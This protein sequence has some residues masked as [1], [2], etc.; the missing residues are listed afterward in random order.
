ML[1]ELASKVEH[2]YCLGWALSQSK[3]FDSQETLLLIQGLGSTEATRRDAFAGLLNGR[4]AI[5]G[6]T[7]LEGLRS[8][9]T[10]KRWTLQQ[11]VDYYILLPFVQSTW[12]ALEDEEAEIQRLYWA[13]ICINGRGDL[14]PKDCEYVI[15]KLAE[16]ERLWAAVDFMALYKN[17]MGN[18]A[19][20]VAEVLDRAILDKRTKGIDWGFVAYGV[21]ELLDLLE[22]SNEIEKAQIAQFE[23]FFLPLLRNYRRPKI[24]YKALTNDPE[25][26]AE[27]LKWPYRAKGEEPSEPTEEKSIRA[28][29]GYDLLRSWTHPPGVNEDGSVDPEKLRS[30]ITRARELTHANGRADVADHHIG[31]VLAHYPK[32]IDGAWPH[33][34]LRD[35]IE[36]LGS[37]EIE[38]GIIIGI[39]NS[40]GVISRSIGEGGTQEREIAERYLDY[41]RKLSDNWPRTARLVKK[42]ADGYELDARRE[43]KRAEL[44]E[45]LM[46]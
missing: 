15:L 28:R 9:E 32:G 33:E 4:A 27:V 41:V 37:E 11:R 2:G 26:F 7:W 30:W 21:G 5:K 17:K 6:Q 39:Y 10:W 29:L 44:D 35:L 40:R 3:V 36:D 46:G 19:K 23:W 24:L 16:H 20:L 1:L 34:T 14:E 13:N 43:D 25:F 18:S 38:K 12:D 45:D 31:Q 42:T 8:S 22:A